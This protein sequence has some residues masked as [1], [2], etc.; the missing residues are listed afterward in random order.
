M[1]RSRRCIVP[2]RPRFQL[3]LCCLQRTGWLS[4]IVL[5]LLSAE[6]LLAQQSAASPANLGRPN[7]LIV[8]TDDQ[9]Y[10][11][12][13]CFGSRTNK[14]PRMDRLA[15]EGTRFTDFNRQEVSTQAPL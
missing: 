8:F 7:I 9:G 15:G 5:T 13:S 1:T 3:V 11:D 10:A 4:A 14:T 12:S 2:V 6:T